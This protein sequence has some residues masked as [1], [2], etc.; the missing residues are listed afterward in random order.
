MKLQRPVAIELHPCSGLNKEYVLMVRIYYV[1]FRC[2][3]ENRNLR[4]T[5][6]GRGMERNAHHPPLTYFLESHRIVLVLV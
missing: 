6:L 4:A 5:D 2:T 1:S 3:E